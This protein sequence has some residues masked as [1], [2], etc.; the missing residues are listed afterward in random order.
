MWDRPAPGLLA[1]PV[2]PDLRAS[3]DLIPVRDE[4]HAAVTEPM[5]SLPSMNRSFWMK[6]NPKAAAS[7]GE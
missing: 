3:F 6:P 5:P 7:G 4:E 2:R 1:G